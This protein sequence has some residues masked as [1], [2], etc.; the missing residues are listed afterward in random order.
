MSLLPIN[1]PE[2]LDAYL[3][4]ETTA[5][6]E[7]AF[8]YRI[9]FGTNRLGGMVDGKE[10]LKQ[11][12]VKALCTCRSRFRIYSDNFGC[13][14]EDLLGSD[15]TEAFIQSEIPRMVREALIYDD[16]IDDVTGIQVSRKGDAVYIVATI[17]SIYGEFTQEVT[18]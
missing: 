12:I 6:P 15:V 5:E 4:T 2:L 18:I 10:A 17:V 9:N 7:P 16:R 1:Q 11:F 3:D 13:E 14:I 8:T